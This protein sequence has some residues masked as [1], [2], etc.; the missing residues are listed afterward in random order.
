MPSAIR[1]SLRLCVSASCLL[2]AAPAADLP[3]FSVLHEE[4]GAWPEILSSIGLQRQPAALSRVF[5]ARAGSPASPE[6]P[7]R[8]ERGAILILEGESSLAGLFGFRRGPD[9][10]KVTS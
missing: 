6:W 7:A 10:V 9:N 8:V 4:P 5:V 1:F 2:L 3:Y